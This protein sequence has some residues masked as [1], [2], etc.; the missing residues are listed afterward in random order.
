DAYLKTTVDEI[1]RSDMWRRGHNAIVVTFDEGSTN[2]GC[3]DANS[4][5][6]RVVTVVI[7]NNQ[8]RPMQDATPYNHYSLVATIQAAFGLGCRFDGTAVG[9]TCDSANGVKPMAPLFDLR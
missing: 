2:L 1:M 3:C 6:G 9:F 4:G 7:R 8:Q 5:G